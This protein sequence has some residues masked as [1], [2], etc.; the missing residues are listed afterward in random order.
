MDSVDMAGDVA[1]EDA[2]Y[3]GVNDNYD[4]AAGSQE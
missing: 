3:E 2:V 1:A 4:E